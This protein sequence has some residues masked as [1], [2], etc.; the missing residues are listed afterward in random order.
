MFV[1]AQAS[2]LFA[3][4]RSPHWDY[5]C[6][7]P[8]I[9]PAHE[10]WRPNDLIRGPNRHNPF[11]YTLSQ[12]VLD[13]PRHVGIF[14]NLRGSAQKVTILTLSSP[15]V[16]AKLREMLKDYPEHIE[17]LQEVLNRSAERSR[18]IPLMPFD[19]AISALEGRLGT[20]IMEARSELAAAEAAGNPQDIAN[21][22]E[23][24]RLMLRAR[25]QSQWIGDESMYSYFQELER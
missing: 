4:I 22:L 14:S 24:E 10:E 7:L 21:A 5:E 11:A 12:I 20:F 8:Y 15:P 1:M 3:G 23:K 19:D 25:L 9:P 18:Q 16:P 13:P 17:R 2:F 6:A